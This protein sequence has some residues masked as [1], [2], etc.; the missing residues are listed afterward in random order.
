MLRKVFPATACHEPQHVRRYAHRE[1][2]GSTLQGT[3]SPGCES[4]VVRH[5]AVMRRPAHA[6]AWA[7]LQITHGWPGPASLNVIG[8][9]SS[10]AGDD[11]TSPRQTAAAAAAAASAA[12]AASAAAGSA[13]SAASAASA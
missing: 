9:Y 10:L 12:S 4:A 2:S 5:S 1:Q 7:A 11:A 13:A 6:S 8:K 3:H